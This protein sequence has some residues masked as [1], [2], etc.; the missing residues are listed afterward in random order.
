MNGTHEKSWVLFFFPNG[1]RQDGE[2]TEDVDAA[3]V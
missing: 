3:A 1:C 2:M